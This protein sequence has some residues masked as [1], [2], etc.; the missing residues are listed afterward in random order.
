MMSSGTRVTFSS[1]SRISCGLLSWIVSHGLKNTL[2][3]FIM[4]S[5]RRRSAFSKRAKVLLTG[6]RIAT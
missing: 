3:F 2:L 1:R 4:L 5:L 6:E